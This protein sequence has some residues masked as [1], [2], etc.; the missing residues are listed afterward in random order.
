MPDN[1]GQKQGRTQFQQ[2]Q[3]GNPAG[4]PKGANNKT[5]TLLRDAILKAAENA[6]DGDLTSYLTECAKAD[7]RS[8]LTLLAKV[9]P[10]QVDGNFQHD[11]LSHEE[12]LAELE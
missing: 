7:R 8:F 6:G 9:M 1:T 10:N 11:F 12:A 5:T 3:S 2:G 4:R